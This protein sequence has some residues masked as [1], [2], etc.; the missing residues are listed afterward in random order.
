MNSFQQT[1]LLLLTANLLQGCGGSEKIVKPPVSIETKLAAIQTLKDTIRP[2]DSNISTSTEIDWSAG[3]LPWD[4]YSIPTFSPNGLHAA[5]QLGEAPPI[6]ILSGNDNSNVTSTSIEMHILDP[7]E[8]REFSPFHIGREGLLL[9]RTANDS[10]FLVEAP[11]GDQGRWIGKVDWSTGSVRW[12]ASDEYINAFPTV[13]ALD[14]IAW[15]RRSQ[16]D[17]RFHLVVKTARGQKIID[18]GKSDWLMPMFLGTDRLR[19]FRI[20]N[21]QLA[22]VEF[23]LRSRDPLL[24]AITLPILES[25]A[26]REIVWQIATTNPVAP[27]HESQAFYHPTKQRMVVWQPGN[28]I[29]TASLLWH[30][31]AATPVTDGSWLVAT[32][33]RIVRQKLGEDDGVHIRNCLGIPFATTSNQWTH[34]MLIPQGNRLEIRAINL[35][36]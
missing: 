12:I 22:L 4:R 15:S 21:K 2:V 14:D 10:Y 27:W 18:D 9:G 30:S 16:D 17:N 1:A 24:T 25:G 35:S 33:D 32:D 20:Q 23:D 19:V 34:Y 31:V 26:T 36:R 5:V 13:N 11:H 8:G 28:S 29:E 7:I 6:K 3:V